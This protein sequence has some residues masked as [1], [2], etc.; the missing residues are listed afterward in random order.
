LLPS[1]NPEIQNQTI[2]MS[3][4]YCT[5]DMRDD[6]E[7]QYRSKKEKRQRKLNKVKKKFRFD[8]RK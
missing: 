4:K 1:G 8:D 6:E 5:T 3:K 7:R 2:R